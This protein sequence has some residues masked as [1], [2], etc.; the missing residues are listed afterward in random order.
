MARVDPDKKANPLQEHHRQ[1]AWQIWAPLGLAIAGVLTLCVLCAL[2]VLGAIPNPTLAE[3]L[4]PLAVIWVL[5]PN[6]FGSL[7]TL[8]ILF[9][10]AFLTAKMLG[11]LPKLGSRILFAVER[12]Q[13]SIQSLSN[14]IAAPV[15][16]S[17]S[18]KAS[19]DKFWEMVLPTKS[20]NKGR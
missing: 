18:L 15:I 14:R 10:C 2:I 3:T 1:A 16:K 7:I 13:Q 19:W 4:A 17:K 6:C 11:G 9:G 20:N 5:I 12:L 8:V